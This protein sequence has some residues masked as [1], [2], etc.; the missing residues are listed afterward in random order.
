MNTRIVG[1]C[2]SLY[3]MVFELA[4]RLVLPFLAGI[5]RRKGWDLDR[6]QILPRV[7]RE[8]RRGARTVAW[9]HAASLGEAKLL[10]QFLGMLEARNPDDCYVVTATTRS[11]VE[12]LER[13][14]RPSIAAAGFLPLDTLPL[15]RS[16]IRRFSVSRLWLLETE[17]WPSMLWACHTAGIP[18]GIAN[19]RVEEKSFVN[20]RR[21]GPLVRTLLRQLDVVMAQNETYAQRFIAL[22][23]RPENLHVVG[24]MKGYIRI[25]RPAATERLQLRR[26]MNL[27]PDDKVITAGCVHKGEGTVLRACL[28]ELK[29]RGRVCR[30]IVVP[31]YLEE[32]AAIAEELGAGVLRLSE[33]DTTVIW[34]CCIVEKL[35]I[36]ETMY[37]IADAAVV[38]GTFVDVGGHNVWEP[39]KFG[40]PVFFGPSRYEQ[41]ASCE[42]LLVFGVG[43]HAAGARDLASGLERMLWTDPGKYESAEALF[44]EHINRQQSVVEPLIP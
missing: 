6:R 10:V 22:G 13:M 9:V 3:S 40:I 27:L 23:V 28:D 24:N 19:A 42:K 34:E 35:G 11:G 33:S 4:R 7:I 18:I 20:Y 25:Q 44:T 21:F 31:R 8:R 36:L 38:G 29:R 30:F 16:L 2:I 32:S 12:Y 41:N 37:R 15:M 17:L 43:F 5:G 14:K 26:R 39:A 1:C